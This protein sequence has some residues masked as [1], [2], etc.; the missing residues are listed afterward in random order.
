MS[1]FSIFLFICITIWNSR[2]NFWRDP[3]PCFE[4]SGPPA[5]KRLDPLPWA[6]GARPLMMS[7]LP[8]M[9]LLWIVHSTCLRLASRGGLL[10]T[11]TQPGQWPRWNQALGFGDT[12]P[13]NN[14]GMHQSHST[15]FSLFSCRR[16]KG[17]FNVP[18]AKPDTRWLMFSA[19]RVKTS[20]D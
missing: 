8:D 20:W 19:S 7:S 16:F 11:G 18:D 2:E 6:F 10:D 14:V 12:D 13:E 4:K 5:E 9:A 1:Y 17:W 3:P 15:H